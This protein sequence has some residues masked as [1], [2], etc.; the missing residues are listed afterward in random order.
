MKS[1]SY[2]LQHLWFQ[3][4]SHGG[5]IC[6]LNSTIRPGAVHTHRLKCV[7]ENWSFA[8][9]GLVC[10]PLLPTALAPWA[11]FLRRFAA[12]SEYF[13]STRLRRNSSSTHALKAPQEAARL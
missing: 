1:S 2:S 5:E 10:F 12:S 6:K 11:A 8:P 13:C 4:L 9:L 3:I 7:R